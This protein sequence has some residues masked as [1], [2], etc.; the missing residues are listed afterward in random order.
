MLLLKPFTEDPGRSMVHLADPTYIH[1]H[2]ASKVC[3][4]T[5]RICVRLL[6]PCFKT[7]WLKPFV[8]A[9]SGRRSSALPRHALR[10][11]TRPEGVTQ[12]NT[13]TRGRSPSAPLVP[14]SPPGF[15]RRR[16]PRGDQQR[17]HSPPAQTDADQ[18][19]G[20]VQARTSPG[21]GTPTRMICSN[22]FSP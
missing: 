15:H 10:S 3:H 17:P 14:R 13:P 4:L 21:P 8:P 12:R 20:M 7:G 9:S 1:F 16:S 11:A 5:T 19:A 6:G 18:H 2:C 22:H